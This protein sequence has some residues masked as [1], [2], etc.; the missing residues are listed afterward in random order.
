MRADLVAD[1]IEDAEGFAA[2]APAWW[3]LWRRAPS[4]TPFQSPAWLIPW[5]RHFHP[6]NLFA[7]AV[8]HGERLVGLAPFYIE[9]GPLGRRILP[10]GISVSD[11][12]DVLL[13]PAYGSAAARTLV[14][15]VARMDERWDEWSLEE[16]AP[17]AAALALPVPP[18]C[19][20]E[21]VNQSPCPVLVF[22]EGQTAFQ[23][24][25]P[26]KQRRKI[27][28]A[29][30]RANRRGQVV[31]DQGNSETAP[32]IL[33]LLFDLHK[34]RWESRGEAGLLADDCVRNFQREAVPGLIDADLLRLYLLHIGG[35]PAAAYFGF[36][37]R[38]RA[39]AYLTGFSPEFTY[40]SPGSLLLAH[41]MGQALAEGAREFHFLRG[42]EAYKYDWGGSDRWNVRRS[43]RQARGRVAHA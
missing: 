37:H 40:E 3:D 31:M 38:D 1:T 9:H 17:G 21:L 13:D 26:P 30:N 11:H 16:V 18:G 22:S 28:L 36:M 33:D 34:A 35:E 20:E 2:L 5:W 27:N 4:A 15:A 32:A 6:G 7:V 29:R 25:L 12:L 42:R 10:V 39:Y 14:D 43:F 24:S 19:T 23:A 41:A 8:R